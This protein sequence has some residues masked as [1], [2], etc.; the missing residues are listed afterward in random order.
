MKSPDNVSELSWAELSWAELSWAELRWYFGPSACVECC[1]KNAFHHEH[2][3][4][5]L[6]GNS[7]SYKES[8]NC[9]DNNKKEK[10]ADCCKSK[11][12]LL[13]LSFFLLLLKTAADKK[14]EEEEESTY[15][16]SLP[17]THCSAQWT[18]DDG[19]FPYRRKTFFECPG[20]AV[21]AV[22]TTHTHTPIECV[23]EFVTVRVNISFFFFLSYRQQ[24]F[25]T[26]YYALLNGICDDDLTH[27]L[28]H[29]RESSSSLSSDREKRS[30]EPAATG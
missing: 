7:S 18:I 8:M 25:T 30:D 29:S 9:C 14:E 2:W 21:T 27:W 28:T 10:D 15:R 12:F 13:F 23:R 24:Q 4:V 16:F 19:R 26:L 17:Y 1:S 11:F 5:K 6:V 22:A 3:R 20:S